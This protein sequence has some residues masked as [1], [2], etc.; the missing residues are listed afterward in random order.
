MIEMKTFFAL[1]LMVPAIVLGQS[2]QESHLAFRVSS[3]AVTAPVIGY[4][5]TVVAG[6]SNIEMYRDSRTPCGPLLNVGSGGANTIML[7]DQFD[8]IIAVS[9]PS[10]FVLSIGANDAHELFDFVKWRAAFNGMALKLYRLRITPVIETPLPM[11]PDK[12]LGADY[13]DQEA[14]LRIVAHIRMVATNYG[15]VL[16]DQFAQHSVNGYMP[17]GGTQDGV[18]PSAT[19]FAKARLSRE[20]AIR[21]AWRKRGISC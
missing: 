18:H 14:L 5:G 19:T 9:N 21:A 13:F 10:V 16:N 11:E 1:L 17:T 6:D 2:A 4:G 12:P 20:Q 7:A 3:L 8:R 15:F